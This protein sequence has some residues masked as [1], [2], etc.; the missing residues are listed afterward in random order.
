M[1]SMKVFDRVDASYTTLKLPTA[2]LVLRIGIIAD[3]EPHLRVR[4]SNSHY[5]MSLSEFPS[6]Q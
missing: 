4:F 6:R 5:R 2:N 3:R 1:M